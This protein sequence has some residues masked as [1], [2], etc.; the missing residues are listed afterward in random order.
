MI[1]KNWEKT[2]GWAEFIDRGEVKQ[3]VCL[4][5]SKIDL[6]KKK[7]KHK[8]LPADGSFVFLFFFFMRI[9]SATDMHLVFLK[10]YLCKMKH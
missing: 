5:T 1:F 10:A 7:K 6:K 9:I 8:H 2:S 4:E 3:D